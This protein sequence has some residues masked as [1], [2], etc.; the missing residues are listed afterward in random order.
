[1][2]LAR[3]RSQADSLNPS[4]NRLPPAGTFWDGNSTLTRRQITRAAL[5]Y[6]LTSQTLT[7]EFDS[8]DGLTA[9][10]TVVDGDVLRPLATASINFTATDPSGASLAS[11]IALMVHRQELSCRAPRHK[12]VYE[13]EV[14]TCKPCEDRL[15]TSPG[16]STCDICDGRYYFLPTAVFTTVSAATCLECPEGTSCNATQTSATIETWTLNPGYWCAHHRITPTLSLSARNCAMLV[17]HEVVDISRMPP[18]GDSPT[19]QMQSSSVRATWPM[20]G[21]QA[22]ATWASTAT[23]T[24]PKASTRPNAF[25]A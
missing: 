3:Y 18:A 19:A 10:P 17:P 24:V 8:L 22:V 23:A 25:A 5:P 11:S 20:L 1:M 4:G 15:A 13:G 21:V 12:I 16:S 9:L 6:L 7:M 2:Q 14:P